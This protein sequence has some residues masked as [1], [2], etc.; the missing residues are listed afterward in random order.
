MGDIAENFG[1]TAAGLR[2]G[3]PEPRKAPEARKNFRAAR[4]VVRPTH[5][6]AA[7]MERSAR[8]GREHLQHARRCDAGAAPALYE[9]K[10]CPP[11][12]AI[13]EGEFASLGCETQ[14]RQTSYWQ[15][16]ALGLP[17]RRWS[18]GA[19]GVNQVYLDTAR[20]LTQVAPLVFVDKTFALKGA[21]RS[22]CSFAICHGC[23]SISI[24]LSSTTTCPANGR[25]TPSPTQFGICSSKT[26]AHSMDAY[27]SEVGALVCF[28]PPFGRSDPCSGLLNSLFFWL[29]S[30]LAWL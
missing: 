24:W 8:A 26:S 14:S 2:K 1:P 17:I 20:L 25:S 5:L 6:A 29:R 3:W 11:L 23:R 7:T 27:V 28:S 10:D 30:V 16:Q 18:F 21:R 9:R 22:I 4:A 15:Q 12:S 19:Q 13:E